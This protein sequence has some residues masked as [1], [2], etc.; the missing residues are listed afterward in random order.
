MQIFKSEKT[1]NSRDKRDNGGRRLF[2]GPV[3]G[4]INDGEI[5]AIAPIRC[6]MSQHIDTTAQEENGDSSKHRTPSDDLDTII[7]FPQNRQKEIISRI[8]IRRATGKVL[9]A[10]SPMALHMDHGRGSSC[11]KSGT[12][13]HRPFA[14]SKIPET[15]IGLHN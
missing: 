9:S 15:P 3:Y 13:K 6:D 11:G 1:N 4:R 7:R 12:L 14:T 5:R 8:G 10:A 2:P